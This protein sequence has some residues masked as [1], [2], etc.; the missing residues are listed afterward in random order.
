[1]MADC[2]F[3]MIYLLNTKKMVVVHSN[4]GLPEGIQT[5]LSYFPSKQNILCWLIPAISPRLSRRVLSY[6]NLGLVESH[7]FW[8]NLSQFLLET[9]TVMAQLT[10]ISM[11]LFMIITTLLQ[12]WQFMS[13]K[14]VFLWDYTFYKWGFVSTYNWYITRAITV[15][16]RRYDG[17]VVGPWWRSTYPRIGGSV[18]SFSLV[19][20]RLSPQKYNLVSCNQ[21]YNPHITRDII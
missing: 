7:F 6:V 5:C 2:H 19:E 13:Y 14:W 21:G 4:C 9:S 3:K 17:L 12:F 11:G 15:T 10:V 18:A 8:L 20:S 16:D 1:M